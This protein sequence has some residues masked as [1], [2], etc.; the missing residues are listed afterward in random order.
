MM[1]RDVV[2]RLLLGLIMVVVAYAVIR[3][4]AP[5]RTLL[6]GAALG[7]GALALVALNPGALASV[8][9]WAGLVGFAAILSA[10][11]I[12]IHPNPMVSVLFLIVNLFC[13]ALFYL[14]LNAQFLAAIQIII[15]AGAI[16]VLFLFVVMLLN[17]KAEEGLTARGGPQ[18]YGAIVLGG[19]F[20]GLL[21]D[22][23]LHRGPQPYFDPGTF[24][25]G[26]GTARELGG[27]LFTR[28]LFAFEAAS[29]LLIAAMIGAVVLAKR[30]LR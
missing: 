27:L 14:F 4:L 30:R 2:V 11:M 24:A 8:E 6:A 19:L 10:L 23:I 12:V 13:V 21:F 7:A 25:S 22:A 29:L 5:A 15:Y 18:R 1:E 28:Y 20:A 16:M 3:I 26:F 9:F 17:L